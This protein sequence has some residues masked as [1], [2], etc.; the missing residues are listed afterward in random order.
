MGR[1]FW[2]AVVTLGRP[3]PVPPQPIPGGARGRRRRQ[4]RLLNLRFLAYRVHTMRTIRAFS[5]ALVVGLSSLPGCRVT[6]RSSPPQQ[7][8]YPPPQQGYYPPPQQGYPPPQQ[9][10]PPPQQGYYP[11]PQQG[12]PTAPPPQTTAPAPASDDL[13]GVLS[14]RASACPGERINLNN[15]RHD[16]VCLSQLLRP[17]AHTSYIACC[18]RTPCNP[19]RAIDELCLDQLGAVPLTPTGAQVRQSCAQRACKGRAETHCRLAP[20]F[21][22]AAAAQIQACLATPDCGQVGTCTE[23]TLD[24]WGC[25]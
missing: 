12:G 5:L 22:D 3:S 14:R 6:T 8:Y 11:P 16:Q 7:G 18:A 15:C 4:G 24:R 19:P 25:P 21:N 2:E 10:Y 9:G 17:E 1:S 13:C 23:H 20:W